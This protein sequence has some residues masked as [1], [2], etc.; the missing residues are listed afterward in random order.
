MCIYIF[1]TDE[2]YKRYLK[3]TL[4]KFA[5]K[6]KKIV[7]QVARNKVREQVAQSVK[8]KN[9]V[10]YTGS[11]LVK[12]IITEGKTDDERQESTIKINT[13]ISR[14]KIETMNVIIEFHTLSFDRTVSN[15]KEIDSIVKYQVRKL[16]IKDRYGDN[17]QKLYEVYEREAKYLL[18]DFNPDKIKNGSGVLTEQFPK[19]SL[20]SF[21]AK[22]D[23][24]AEI[25]FENTK[26]EK[27]IKRDAINRGS[28]TK[29]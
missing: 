20:I 12:L 19:N 5:T 15:I 1:W 4:K 29:C 18:R 9:K 6:E 23:K 3:D 22:Y 24:W 13:L 7:A 16:Q 26:I 27:T 8:G 25:D 28:T 17:A 21:L 14:Q 11:T 10:R 2:R